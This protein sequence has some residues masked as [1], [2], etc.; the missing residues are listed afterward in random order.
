V[1]NPPQLFS[2]DVAVSC[3][4]DR[5]VDSIESLEPIYENQDVHCVDRDGRSV[6]LLEDFS[7][8][9]ACS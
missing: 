3:T 6:R 7:K 8:S 4:Q 5:N 9:I 1:H 2:G